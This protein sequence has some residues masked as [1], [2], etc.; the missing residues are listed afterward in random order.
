[1]DNIHYSAFVFQ[2]TTY[3]AE[4][5]LSV[6]PEP[7][8]DSKETEESQVIVLVTCNMSISINN[9]SKIMYHSAKAITGRGCHIPLTD[10][11]VVAEWPD[12]AWVETDAY[13]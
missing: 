12:L 11:L 7:K 10:H 9:V 2:Y 3:L 4:L 13:T 1:M 8:P 5:V 6:F